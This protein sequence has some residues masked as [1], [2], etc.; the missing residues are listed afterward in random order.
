MYK[1][2]LVVASKKDKAGVNIT[3][4]LSQFRKNPLLASMD[5]NKPHF[6]FYLCEEDVLK[7]ENLDLGKIEKYDFVIF[8][9]KHKSEKKE[10]TLSIHAPGNW[11]ENNFGGQRWRVCRSSGL[12]QKQ[13]FEKLHEVAEEHHLKDKYKITLEATHH[14]PLINKPC[15]FIEIG[16]T[17][18]EWNDRAAAF[19]IAKTIR[20]VVEEFEENPYNEVAIG[21]GGP[22]YCPNFNKL[23]LNSNV[24]FSHIIPNYVLPLTK[25]MILE[26]IEKTDEDVEFV[27]IDWKG[28]GKVEERDRIVEILEDNYIRWK[29]SSEI[30]K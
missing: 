8:A 2:Y 1:K 4:A 23:Q 6:D 14:G 26:A 12:L 28:V 16:S 18:T 24:A 25:E 17:E 30:G 20:R 21:L 11:G 3:T 13:M 10:K 7:T 19:V 27:V 29:R 5:V 15:V 9:S 22:H